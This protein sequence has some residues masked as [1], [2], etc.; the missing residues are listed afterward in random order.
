MSVSAFSSSSLWRGYWDSHVGVVIKLVS[1]HDCLDARLL[2]CTIAW[3]QEEMC[4]RHTRGQF[5]CGTG[6][7]MLLRHK[8][9]KM[10][11]L[12]AAREEMF[13]SVTRAHPSLCHKKTHLRVSEKDMSSCV[14]RR[15]SSC[16]TR[17]NFLSRDKKTISEA[18]RQTQRHP[19]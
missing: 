16:F 8:R 7:D 19:R 9:R 1:P 15:V 12:L 13:T 10:K 6:R 5:S 3:M 4:C 14:T 11:C 18:S 2:G 17:R